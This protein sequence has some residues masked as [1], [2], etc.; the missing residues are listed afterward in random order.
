MAQIVD[1]I[2]ELTEG[3]ET[4]TPDLQNRLRGLA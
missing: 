1:S 2:H 4:F 3:F